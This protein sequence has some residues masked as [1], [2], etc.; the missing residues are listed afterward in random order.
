MEKLTLVV[1]GYIAEITPD[2][3]AFFVEIPRLPG[4]CTEVDALDEVEAMIR[5][6]KDLWISVARDLGMTILLP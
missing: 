6:A 5:D 4:C 1:D 3:G 2:D